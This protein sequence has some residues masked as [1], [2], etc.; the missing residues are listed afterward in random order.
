MQS[1]I[2]VVVEPVLGEFAAAAAEAVG[3]LARAYP[4]GAWFVALTDDRGGWT[5]VA[6]VDRCYGLAL[7]ESLPW[8][9]T[10]CSRMVLGLGPHVSAR[11]ESCGAYSAALIGL[12]LPLG[13][14]VGTALL[15]PDGSVIGTLCGLD[16][17]PQPEALHDVLPLVTVL[18]GVLSR[19]HA[20]E[21]QGAEARQRA[22]AAEVEAVRCAL[23]GALNRRGWLQQLEQ[24][25]CHAD[26][27]GEDL[28]LLSLDLDDLK[29]TNDTLGHAAGDALLCR[30][31][32]V[33]RTALRPSDLLARLGGDELGVAAVVAGPDGLDQLL[34]R[35]RETLVGAD[36]WVSSGG[37]LRGP[38]APV[39]PAWQEADA[40]MYAV[41]QG[42][43][44]A[45]GGSAGAPR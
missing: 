27:S 14:Y 13:A 9:D 18:A 43:R 6:A 29:R 41:K 37:A 35:V 7:G 19:L 16:P 12:D 40:R 33:L 17:E 22:A 36:L 2:G 38:G 31:V 34:R 44:S 11:V 8:Q 32:A 20:A 4:L 42:R 10:L 15:R 39:A 23:T 26:R 28:A 3:H 1:R 24:L 25:V 5:P 45:A 30:T 21:V